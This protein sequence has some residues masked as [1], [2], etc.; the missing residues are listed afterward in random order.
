METFDQ[1]DITFKNKQILELGPGNSIALAM[2]FL[3]NSSG[4]Y[5]MVDK[6]PRILKTEKQAKHLLEQITYFEEK[7]HS[8]LNNFINKDN[9]EFNEAFLTYMQD[10]A[11]DLRNISSH[12]VD[13]ILSISVLEHIRDVE[14]SFKE[15]RRILKE[16]G[17][18]YHS[19][20]LR[21]H[22]NSNEPLKFLKY[23]DFAW[24]NFLTKEG[25]SYT[26]RLRIYDYMELLAKYGFEI[27]NINKIIYD[28]DLTE[29]KSFIKKFRDEDKE[30]LKVLS[31]EILA[32]K[33]F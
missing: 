19:I 32:K 4:K 30:N 12:S 24:D 20:D 8:N 31:I 9:L 28:S 14:K 2:N 11:E 16:G 27:I 1:Y 29:Q 7:Y 25:Y 5:L 23:S 3:C 13:I 18:M 10:S 15:M 22:Y 17:V 21:D 26:N 33:R 6:Y